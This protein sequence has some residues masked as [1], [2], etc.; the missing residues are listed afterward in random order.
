MAESGDGA[1]IKKPP[2][3][4]RSARP[5]HN[6]REHANVAAI[7]QPRQEGR[8]RLTSGGASGEGAS[9]SSAVAGGGLGIQLGGGAGTGITSQ[10]PSDT[11][12]RKRTKKFVPPEGI[13]S[14]CSVC[15]KAF[16]SWRSLFGHMRC[17]PERPWR[18]CFPP[19]VVGQPQRPRAGVYIF[20][21]YIVH[22]CVLVC[23]M[24]YIYRTCI[25][26]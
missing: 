1:S 15:G 22:V 14:V 9:G 5:Q 6:A 19:P 20:Y 25:C 24:P 11:R 18:G 4:K 21:I 17:H 3:K 10:P 2:T 23:F 16:A 8:P 13:E 12:P 7:D 26:R